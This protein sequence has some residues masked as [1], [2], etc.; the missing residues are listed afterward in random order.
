MGMTKFNDSSN[1]NILI[2]TLTSAVIN[3]SQTATQTSIQVFSS[4]PTQRYCLYVFIGSNH[5]HTL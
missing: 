2:S 5:S 1:N 4:S 3:Q